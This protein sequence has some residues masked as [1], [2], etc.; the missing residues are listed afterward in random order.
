VKPIAEVTLLI[1][2]RRRPVHR[3]S[4]LPCAMGLG[5]CGHDAFGR[6]VLRRSFEKPGVMQNLYAAH[7]ERVRLGKLGND[8][9]ESPEPLCLL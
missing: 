6:R 9:P 7:C 8:R 4:Y 1:S 3:V 5:F 2:S